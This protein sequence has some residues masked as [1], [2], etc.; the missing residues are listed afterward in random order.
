MG[1]LFSGKNKGRRGGEVCVCICVCVCVC[2]EAIS[3]S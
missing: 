2:F 3:R 1:I